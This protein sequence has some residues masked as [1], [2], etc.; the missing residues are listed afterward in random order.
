MPKYSVQQI[1][2]METKLSEANAL[3]RFFAALKEIKDLPAFI[4]VIEYKTKLYTQ[5]LKT[6]DNHADL[7]RL[8]GKLSV[9][10]EFASLEKETL[11][12]RDQLA[13]FLNE[14]KVNG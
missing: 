6:K 10:T 4:N 8:Q 5:A 12:H 9:I 2:D 1:R 11:K 3:L 13:Q 14:G 7:M